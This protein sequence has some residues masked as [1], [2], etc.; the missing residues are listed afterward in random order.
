MQAESGDIGVRSADTPVSA[1][2]PITEKPSETPGKSSGK[3]AA[4]PPR[5]E[6]IEAAITKTEAKSAAKSSPELGKKEGESAPGALPADGGDRVRNEKGQFVAAQKKDMPKA[7]KQDYRP[8]WDALDPE[9][10]NWVAELEETR[11]KQFLAGID[12]YKQD[13]VWARQLKPVLQPYEQM[14]QQQYGG[15]AQGIQQLINLSNFAAQKPKEFVEWFTK[16][17]GVPLESQAATPEQAANQQAIEGVLRPY[18]ERIAGLE[19]QLQQFSQRQSQTSEQ[20]ALVVVNDFLSQKD[21][22]GSLK[23]PVTDD[24]IDDF[25]AHIAFVR[26]QHGDWDDQRV[27]EAAYGSLG[28]THPAMR[29][30]RLERELAERKAKETAEL[31]AKKAAA[32]SVTGAPSQ[33]SSAKLDARDRRSVIAAAIDRVQR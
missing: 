8:K 18:L 32:V 31:E 23:F 29:Q 6:A 11:E 33:A 1:E 14:F 28:W 9:L 27:L 30:V 20:Q 2:K 26:G 25:A 12:P 4:P 13:A 10:A 15:V 17:R 19:Q 3:P 5:R 21:D 24:A 16:T 7:W 22:K